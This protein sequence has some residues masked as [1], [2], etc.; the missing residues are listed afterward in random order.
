MQYQIPKHLLLNNHQ[1]FLCMCMYKTHAQ[2]NTYIRCLCSILTFVSP[3]INSCLGILIVNM[4]RF[5]V[6]ICGK[7]FRQQIRVHIQ[8]AMSYIY[9]HTMKLYTDTHSKL[10]RL[11]TSWHAIA[12]RITNLLCRDAHVMSVQCDKW[13]LLCNPFRKNFGHHPFNRPQLLAYW[14]EA[15]PIWKCHVVTYYQFTSI[16]IFQI[17]LIGI[18]GVPN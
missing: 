10:L 6:S 13:G 12:F 5:I 3:F 16:H 17:P 8:W 14:M 15:L 1:S 9:A 4:F 7:N 2:Y 11:M 18:N